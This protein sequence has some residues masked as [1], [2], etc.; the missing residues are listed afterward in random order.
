[1]DTHQNKKTTRRSTA[2]SG[3][4]AYYNLLAGMNFGRTPLGRNEIA[5]LTLQCETTNQSKN[6]PNELSNS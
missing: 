4:L 5:T 2:V 1:M 6:N 3:S